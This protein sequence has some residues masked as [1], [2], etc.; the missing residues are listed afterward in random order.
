MI[1][2]TLY[3]H[4]IIIALRSIQVANALFAVYELMQYVT[5]CK[6]YKLKGVWK[7]YLIS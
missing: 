7:F 1:P 2:F 6:G 4:K 5:I 3:I